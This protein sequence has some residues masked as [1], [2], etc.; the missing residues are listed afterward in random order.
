[1]LPKIDPLPCAQRQASVGERNRELDRRQRGADVGGHVIGPFVAMTEEGVA[2][3]YKSSEEAF[4]VSAHVRIGILLHDQARRRVPDEEREQ[5]GFH[6]AAGRPVDDWTSDLDKAAPAGVEAKRRIR[7][8]KHRRRSDESLLP[9]CYQVFQF[10]EDF[11][12]RDAND[13]EYEHGG[14]S[15]RRIEL[16]R[17]RLY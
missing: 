2:I 9:L 10:H 16:R 17:V 15:T 14:V 3:R 5:A 6:V 8:A 11:R 1:M 7:L 12:E 13:D 4:E